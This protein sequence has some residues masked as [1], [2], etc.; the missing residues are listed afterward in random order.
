MQML[1]SFYNTTMLCVVKDNSG[2]WMKISYLRACGYHFLAEQFLFGRMFH[3]PFC[4]LLLLAIAKGTA[5]SILLNKNLLT[6]Y[7]FSTEA[8]TTAAV[9][10]QQ[11]TR[12]D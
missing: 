11:W 7:T 12:E 9:A 2:I 6:R 1:F 4:R 8:L 10:I 3:Y 5:K